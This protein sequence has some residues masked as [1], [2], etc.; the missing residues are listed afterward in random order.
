MAFA[1]LSDL[2]QLWHWSPGEGVC[3]LGGHEQSQVSESCVPGGQSGRDVGEAA[4]GRSHAAAARVSFW[5]GNVLPWGEEAAAS[6]TW[7]QHVGQAGGCSL[8][9]RASRGPA[10]QDS[11]LVWEQLCLSL[12]QHCLF[13]TSLQLS[14][15]SCLLLLVRK[16]HPWGKSIVKGPMFCLDG[17]SL[18]H[19]Q[20]HVLP[21]C[22]CPS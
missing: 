14:S 19:G 13:L 22:C 11:R 18:Q 17:L 5:A 16:H 10:A 6:G 12:A 2:A 1:H 21:G 4:E 9:M 3:R 7:P 8:L 20:E 15:L